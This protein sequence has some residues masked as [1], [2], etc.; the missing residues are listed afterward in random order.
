LAPRQAIIFL[1]RS[2]DNFA[3]GADLTQIVFP[4]NAFPIGASFA[5]RIK[6]G[7]LYK[8]TY[9]PYARGDMGWS[10]RKVADLYIKA[11]GINVGKWAS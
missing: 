9:F 11:G 4:D 7:C 6:A 10:A 1:F 2:R 3:F 5:G 8:V